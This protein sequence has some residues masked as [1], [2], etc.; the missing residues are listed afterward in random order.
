M[1]P[2]ARTPVGRNFYRDR[3]ALTR[4]PRYLDPYNS[5]YYGNPSSPFFYMYLAELQN[6]NQF[7]DG[8]RPVPYQGQQCKP[9]K[10]GVSVVAL[11]LGVI[12][13]LI[14]GGIVGYLGGASS[15]TG[16]GY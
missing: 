6:S 11:V 3:A 16:R 15:N 5:A 13:A 8:A 4:N 2:N 12:F 1:P 9:K 14:L 7:G 10:K